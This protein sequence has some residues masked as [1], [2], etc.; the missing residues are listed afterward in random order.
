M[1]EDREEV[2]DG[3]AALRAAV[4]ARPVV[5]SEDPIAPDT[6]A[7]FLDG[8]L[9][10][11]EARALA[12]RVGEDPQLALELR[13][14]HELRAAHERAATGKST[15]ESMPESTPESTPESMPESTP[16]STSRSSVWAVV[17]ALAAAAVV[18]FVLRPP[19]LRDSGSTEVRAGGASAIEPVE[20][21]GVLPRDAFE[22]RWRGG[23]EAISYDV[24]VT[25]E[26]LEP[27]HQAFD[28]TEAR[29]TVPPEALDDLPEGAR[30]LWRVVAVDADGRR[31]S[32]AAFGV[33]LR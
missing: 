17:G 12:L 6:L 3:M 5:A 33:G 19:R 13:L 21:D 16:A 28:L 27:V 23:P 20:R 10:P 29:H 11:D 9:P 18:L 2:P 7:D 32:S 15:P 22:L 26:A 24:F 31:T 30:L 1:S 8:N 4:Q 25:T 14:A